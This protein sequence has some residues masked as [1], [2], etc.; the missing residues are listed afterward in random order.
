M[1]HGVIAEEGMPAE[2]FRN[3]SNPRERAFLR[4]LVDH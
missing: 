2:I 4:G 1:D 3:R